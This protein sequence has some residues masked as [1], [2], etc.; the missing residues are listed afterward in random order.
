M[1]PHEPVP[2]KVVSRLQRAAFYVADCEEHLRRARN[3]LDAAIYAA[4][5]RDGCQVAAVADAA[6]VSRETVYRATGR[7]S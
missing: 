4:V 3:G 5:V 2:A 1:P 7:A 6:G